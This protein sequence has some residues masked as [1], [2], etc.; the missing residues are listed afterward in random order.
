MSS[1]QVRLEMHLGPPSQAGCP[2]PAMDLWEER[3]IDLGRQHLSPGSSLLPCL[4]VSAQLPGSLVVSFP[5]LVCGH[6][7][8][9]S[10]VSKDYS[11]SVCV[12]DY[13]SHDALLLLCWSSLPLPMRK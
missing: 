3:H 12:G 4:M 11:G 7:G 10:F 8:L 2:Q 13:M 1:V 6:A 5:S 9:F